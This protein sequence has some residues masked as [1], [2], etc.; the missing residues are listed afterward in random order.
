MNERATMVTM[1]CGNPTSVL[2][3]CVIARNF[4]DE[5]NFHR[6]DFTK[7]E[8][9]T[10]KEWR[11]KARKANEEKNLNSSQTKQLQD[12]MKK[13][14]TSPEEMTNMLS[15]A[16]KKLELSAGA[17][18]AQPLARA[19]SNP[20]CDYD[21]TMRCGRCKRSWYCSAACQKKSVALCTLHPARRD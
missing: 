20:A 17:A 16:T 6:V 7:E 11:L 8:Y 18:A 1:E 15:A 12:L 4:D 3:D 13:T 19:C 5:N 21:A 9:F 10:D 14:Q 2:G